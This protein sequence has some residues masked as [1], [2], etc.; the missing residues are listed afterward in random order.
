MPQLAE[1][2]ARYPSQLDTANRHELTEALAEGDEAYRET[3]CGMSKFAVYEKQMLAS[4]DQ[5]ISLTDPDSRSMATSGRGSGVVGYNV[6]VDVDAEHHLIVTRKITNN[7][8]DRAQLANM[9]ASDIFLDENATEANVKGSPLADYKIAYFA[10]HGLVAG[11]IAGL[12]KPSLALTLPKKS[13]PVDDSLLTASEQSQLKLNAAGWSCP[14][15]TRWQ[16]RSRGT[17]AVRSR[18][19][20]LLRSRARIARVTM[21]D[22]FRL[23]L[24]GPEELTSSSSWSEPTST[25]R[26]RPTVVVVRCPAPIS[27]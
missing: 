9:P 4:P 16:V 2:V 20:V 6:Q 12:S 3:E 8:S 25:N 24:P 17:S 18:P 26:R 5:K 14:P 22:R 7:G 1:S 15:A 27:S 23:I 13:G 10:T 21:V 11:D 19:G